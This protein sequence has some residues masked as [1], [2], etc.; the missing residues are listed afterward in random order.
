MSS[1]AAVRARLTEGL[2]AL[3]LA[4]ADGALRQ[5]IVYLAL[6]ERWNRTHNLTAVRAP[7]QMVTRHLLDSLAALPWFAGADKVLDVGSGAGLPGIV[8]AVAM[9]ATQFVLCEANA[10][11]Q[12]FLRQAIAGLGLANASVEP[13]RVEQ[14]A[15]EGF[16]VITARAFAPVE[17]IVAL[18]SGLLTPGVRL[19]LLKSDPDDE[20]AALPPGLGAVSVHPLAVPGLAHRRCLVDIVV[21]KAP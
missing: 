8:L 1:D 5:L 18:C 2:D 3:G 7:E 17:R 10:K 14:V 6:L 9:P 4:L 20:L 21:G 16:D 11:K 15:P 19:L 13:R 12:S